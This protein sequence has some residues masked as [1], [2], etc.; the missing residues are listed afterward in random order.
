MKVYIAGLIDKKQSQT[1]QKLQKSLAAEC[2]RIL[3][4]PRK[5]I[6]SQELNTFVFVAIEK[7]NA[8][9]S[10]AITEVESGCLFKCFEK[11]YRENEALLRKQ[12]KN[13][14]ELR[15]T[16]KIVKDF[17]KTVEPDLSKVFDEKLKLLYK[18]VPAS[19]REVQQ[20]SYI[21]VWDL[22]ETQSYRFYLSAFN[23]SV[24]TGQASKTDFDVE[25]LVDKLLITNF[26]AA[27]LE[28]TVTQLKEVINML[29]KLE[30]I[31][32]GTYF[33]ATEA[34]LQNKLE[35]LFRILAA[36]LSSL[37]DIDNLIT[38]IF[39]LYQV[40]RAV[41]TE[42]K[43]CNGSVE[44]NKSISEMN[45]QIKDGE[46]LLLEASKK[47]EECQIYLR[48][49]LEA[50][51]NNIET[52]TSAE[53]FKSS[54]K[55]MAELSVDLFIEA[56]TLKRVIDFFGSDIPY[57][58][59]SK[60]IFNTQTI[61]ISGVSKDAIISV[62][63]LSKNYNLGNT[64]VYAL[65]GVTLDV[66]EGEFLA[67]VG[68]SGAGKTTLLNCMAGLDSP[69]HGVVLFR[70]KDLHKMDDTAKSKARLLE[71]GF[72]FQSY[73]LLPHFNARENVALPADLAGLSKDLKTRIEELLSGVGLSNQA[74]QLPATLSGGQMQRV[75]IA[76][77]LTNQ[78]A[79]IFAD[80]PTGD[81]DSQ[82]GKQVMDLLKKFHDETKTTII[83]ITHAEE[84]A[85]YADRRVVMEDGMIKPQK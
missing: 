54:L 22:Q 37:Q 23:P 72:I 44:L 24:F 70:G 40:P 21:S 4:V 16:S 61:D 83:V 77:A 30:T 39:K 11:Y 14:Q 38:R 79:V 6:L 85:D 74:K 59:Y 81:L 67:I 31:V 26:F 73:A 63:G 3:H 36:K 7:N 56:E 62:L 29:K 34:K 53:T 42:Y 47:L 45:K 55:P 13:D 28:P 15:E 19:Y 5:A 80:E 75:A 84:V 8:P 18:N 27:F 64:T 82:T 66:K 25:E 52:I 10:K 41:F 50:T 71:M 65:R 9:T 32:V 46:K 49:Y 35:L 51:K 76:R 57:F 69:D 17:I 68:N 33:K 2:R 60:D 43:F 12:L 1:T 78:P 48:D 58:V 20:K